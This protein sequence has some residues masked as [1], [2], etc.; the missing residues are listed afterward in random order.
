M[1]DT[2]GKLVDRALREWLYPPDDQPTRTTLNAAIS[3]SAT[4]LVYNTALLTAEE[5][6]LL[7][8]GT[9]I[10][11][12]QE[13]ILVGAVDA[14]TD[15]LSS[16]V[17]GANGTSPAAH[18]IS[19]VITVRP[20]YPRRVVFDALA[21]ATVSLYPRLYRRRA[22]E[23]TLASGHTEVPADIELPESF[24]WLDGV[25]PMFPRVRVI[26]VPSL[27]TGKALLCLDAPAN[28]TGTLVYRAR[29]PSPSSESELL[30]EDLGILPE[31]ENP[32]IVKAIAHLIASRDTDPQTSEYLTRQLEAQFQ[33]QNTGQG[34][35]LRESML[36]YYE[37]LMSDLSRNTEAVRVVNG[38]V[39][40]N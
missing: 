3:N 4:S 1:P 14:G 36:R 34:T 28:T 31:Y 18:A 16:L 2:F 24:V 13:Q 37:Y 12:G 29:F 27:S 40:G 38:W 39:R 32:V 35:R 6:L 11:I 23:I 30:D 33:G 7:G 19:S 8:P 20:T 5:E 21:R 9:L 10:E 17:R 26:D 25:Y 15:T 22:T